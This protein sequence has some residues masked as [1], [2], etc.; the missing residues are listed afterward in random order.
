MSLHDQFSRQFRDLRVSVT[1]RCNFRCPYCMPAEI[2]GK[3]YHF[4]PKAALL[5]FEEITR[6][7]RIAATLGAQKIRLTG[8]EP[9]LRHQLEN[10]IAQ[11]RT[12]DGV[13]DIALTTNGFLLSPNAKSLRQAGLHRLTVSVDTLDEETFQEMS[14]GKAD[15][16]T[17]LKGIEAAEKAGFG[18]L[19][20]NTVV[21]R[22][23]NDH[24][25]VPMARYFRDRGHILRFIEYM[26]VGNLNEW[27]R[28]EVVTAREI[29]ARLDSALGLEPIADAAPGETARRYRYRNSE[30]EVGVIASVSEPFC[31]ACSRLRLSP[32]GTIY[33]CLFATTGV[34]LRGPLRD[35]ASDDDLA[36]LIRGTW[37]QRTDRYSQE[38]ANTTASKQQKVEMYHIGG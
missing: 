34:D 3:R 13:D 4:L 9:L 23:I 1:D 32:E 14:G 6:L 7:S 19:K 37:H 33:T 22:G 28:E 2:Y 11:L 15:L 31:G 26:D 38:R 24:E 21:Q 20:I 29:V 27:K 17:V 35:G 8:G 12:L 10:L 30:N 18:P 16:A 36:A 5:T 25:I